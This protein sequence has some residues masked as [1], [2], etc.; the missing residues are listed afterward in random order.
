MF[1]SFDLYLFSCQ[2]LTNII[3][4]TKHFK[5]FRRC[6]G[7]KTALLQAEVS[8]CVLGLA[9]VL[10]CAWAFIICFSFLVANCQLFFCLFTLG[11]NGWRLC[12]RA[13]FYHQTFLRSRNFKFTK[14]CHTK[15]THPPDAKPLLAACA[16]VRP[17]RCPSIS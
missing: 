9:N 10:F 6:V 15:H 17:K 5:I 7:K 16:V 3:H 11:G 14:N 1:L 8:A 4:F 12:V 2:Y 13:G